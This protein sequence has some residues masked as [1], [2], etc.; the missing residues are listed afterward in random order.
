MATA[1]AYTNDRSC[2]ELWIVINEQLQI[3]NLKKTYDNKVTVLKEINLSIEKEEFLVL[4]GPSGCGKST[5]LRIIAG[6]ETASTGQITIAGKDVTKAPPAERD[7]AMVFQD[8]ALYPHMTVRENLAFGLKMRKTPKDTI[9]KEI[10]RAAEILDIGHLL[11]RRPAQLSGGQRQR[12]AI[13]RAIVRRASLFLF[14]EPLSNLD[15]K[16]RSQT[17]IE[18]ADLHQKIKA[19][20]VY[21][22]HDQVEAMTLADRIVVLN[23]GDIQQIG[24]PMELY[25]KP[26][27]KFVASFIGSP[28]MNFFEGELIIEG[29][30]KIFR[31]GD[32]TIDFSKAPTPKNSQKCTLGLRPEAIKVLADSGREAEGTVDMQVRVLFQEPHG[33][34]N[35][36]IGL[37]NDKQIIIR[38]ANPKRLAVMNRAK[39]DDLLGASIDLKALHW[40]ASGENGVRLDC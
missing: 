34:E 6:L 13:G 17:R 8:Y 11:D 22:T 31:W 30:K 2:G 15:A 25:N 18:L 29:D 24:T 32:E 4:V 5:L 38:S 7:I 39:K 26:G 20:T 37:I 28:N 36:L 21:V 1:R 27:N 23:A 16:L 3:S 35:H 33:H 9:E 10:Q 14:D 40:F 12:V 19:T